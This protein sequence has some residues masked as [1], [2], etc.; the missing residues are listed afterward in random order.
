MSWNS[1]R[2]GLNDIKGDGV[3]LLLGLIGRQG[4]ERMSRFN[5]D[6]QK[7]RIGREF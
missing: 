7:K 4:F 6:Y 3:M 1:C 5:E 2:S